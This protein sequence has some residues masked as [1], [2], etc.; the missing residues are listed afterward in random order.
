M[1]PTLS[2]RATATGALIAAAALLTVGVQA[3]TATA[4]PDSAPAAPVAGKADPGALPRTLS[5]AQ[6]AALIREADAT[7]A[8]TAKEL[9]LGAQEKLVVRD[10]VQDVDGTTHTRY[11]RTYQGLPVLGGDLVVAATKA[12]ATQSVSKASTS[13]LKNVATTADIAPAVAEKQA[14]GAAA[15]DGS[16]KTEADRAPRKVVWMAQGSP[17]LAY[18]TVVGGLQHDGTP[19]ELHV[20]TDAA[21]GKK[22]YEWQGVQNGVGNTQYSGQVTLG[23]TQSGSTYNLT[24]G[25]RGSHKTYNLNRGTSGTGTLF[26]NST[27]TWGN[28]APANLET[29]GADAAYGAGETWDYFKNVHG[30][31]G[32][33][34]DGVGAYSRVHYSSGYVNAFWQDSCFCMTYGDGSGNAKPLTSIDVAAHEMSHGVTANTAGLIYSGESGG[35]NEATSDIFAA[36]V[37]FYANSPQDPGDYLVGEKIDINGNGTPL[38][39]MDKPSKDGASKDYWYSGIGNVDV[40]Y[41]SGPA[42]HWF[43]LLSEG[44]GAK[45]VNGVSYDSPTSDG[46]PVTGIGRAKAEQIWFKALTTKFTSTT[47][48]AAARTGTL[49]VAGELYGTTSAEYTAVAN[50][51]AGISVGTRP[52]GGGGGGTV[53]ENTGAVAIPDNG[54]AVT[55]SV[56]VTGV[57]GNAPSNLL[58]GVDITHTW[59]GDLVIDLVAPD[60]TA[61]RLKNASGSDSADDVVE[62]FSVNASSKVANG[63]WQL[64]VQDVAAQDT[65]RINSFKLTFPTS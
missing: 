24:D 55:S 4:Q 60:G 37:E 49:A 52:G 59:R 16:K 61:F 54:A 26:S 2:R 32:I 5:P 38:R 62:T 44:S 30:R 43:Y 13:A 23:S 48:Y 31:T 57:T 15:A 64:K 1:R 51:W 20:V 46:L 19:N 28:G 45:V 34:G 63:T 58:V 50:A 12:G 36:A 21:T 41:S 6:R 65:G 14:L 39:Y 25:G 40:H 10:V 8:A 27:D 3:G 7:K 29:A 42:N 17:T 33:R 56:T 18:E 35:L 22:L 47:N 53:F 11:E 9:G